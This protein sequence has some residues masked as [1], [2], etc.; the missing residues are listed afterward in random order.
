MILR[1][2]ASWYCWFESRQGHSCLSLLSVVCRHVKFS[3]SEWWLVQSSSTEC[4]MSEC[5]RETSTT[6]SPW[7]DGGSRACGVNKKSTQ[8]FYN[9]NIWVETCSNFT[10]KKLEFYTTI[11]VS[12]CITTIDLVCNKCK[13]IRTG[14]LQISYW[15]C[16]TFPIVGGPGSSVGIA[17]G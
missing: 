13:Y 5:D 4:G 2:F 9:T 16:V 10:T 3:G 14:R 8:I 11:V 17:T 12:N 1:P 7:P 6:R 15:L